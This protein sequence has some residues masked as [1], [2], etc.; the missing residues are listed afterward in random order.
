MPRNPL[1]PFLLVQRIVGGWKPGASRP[2]RRPGP[3]REPVTAGEINALIARP[4]KYR[5][6]MDFDSDGY[7]MRSAILTNPD[8]TTGGN[9]GYRFAGSWPSSP[10]TS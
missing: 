5:V 7:V 8:D 10:G 4:A 2:R 3:R 9:A 1:T 6:V